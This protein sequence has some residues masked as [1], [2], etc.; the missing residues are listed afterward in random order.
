M[1]E[2][3]EL[4]AE[5]IDDDVV[6]RIELGGDDTVVVTSGATHVYRSEGLLSDESV[7]THDHD[8]DRFDVDTG[9][10]KSVLRFESMNGDNSFKVPGSNAD[11]VVDAVLEGV[12]RTKGLVDPGERVE[13]TYRFSELTFVVTDRRFLKHVGSAVFDGEPEMIRYEDVTD[14][15]FE[16][17]TVAM[18]VVVE[19]NG[20]SQRVKV[21][22]ENARRVR[23]TVENAFLAFHDASSLDSLRT[24]LADEERTD[25]GRDEATTSDATT[26]QSATEATVDP[27]DSDPPQRRSDSKSSSRDNA[28]DGLASFEFPEDEDP[29]Q[30]SASQRREL[31]HGS[32][33]SIDVEDIGPKLDAL[34]TKLDRQNELLEAQQA[35]IDQLVKELR[36]GR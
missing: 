13:A 17:G 36:R 11:R 16:E 32:S 10:R 31:D 26:S 6:D 15:D 24:A 14:L 23:Q 34:K 35:T 4:L 33:G 27:F 1:S 21:P 29:T 22:N 5:A 20:R 25:V 3:P 28:R 19:T 30:G 12:L 2:L 18:Q 7:E 8:V 9:R